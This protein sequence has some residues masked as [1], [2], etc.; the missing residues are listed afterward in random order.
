MPDFAKTTFLTEQATSLVA[1]Q[2]FGRQRQISFR[3]RIGDE[4][5]N[6]S[7]P[8]PLPLSGLAYVD[9]DLSDADVA[10]IAGNGGEGGPAHDAIA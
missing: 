1:G 3:F 9:A 10:S 6:Q 5:F 8:N 2:N 4:G 7:L